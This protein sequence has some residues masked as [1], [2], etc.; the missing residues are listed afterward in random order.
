MIRSPLS[1]TA[2]EC[3]PRRARL[4]AAVLVWTA[5]AGSLLLLVSWPLLGGMI[6][7]NDDM[8]YSRCV[9]LRSP[10]ENL[11]VFWQHRFFRPLDVL[12]GYL[13]DPDTLDAGR[14]VLLHLPALAA[15][16][17][18]LW[19]ALRRLTPNHVMIAWPVAVAWLAAH[20]STAAALWQHDTISQ[21]W[22]AACGLWLGI[23]VWDAVAAPG[24]DRAY[25]RHAAWAAVLTL[26]GLLAK[27]VFCGWVAAASLLLIL[28]ALGALR[29]GDRRAVLRLGGL[30]LATA[31]VAAAFLL[32]RWAF[33]GLGNLSEGPDS[34]YEMQVGSNVVRN[35][36]L[37]AVGYFSAA[38]VHVVRD[39]VAWPLLRVLPLA[40]I[41]TGVLVATT[42]WI[43]S[44]W[45]PRSWP[46][47]PPARTVAAIAL[48]TFLG[49][50]AT[51]PSRQVS[52]VYLMGPNAGAALLVALGVIGLGRMCRGAGWKRKL[53]MAL[54]LGLMATIAGWGM[55]SRAMHARITWVS[56]S[57]LNR[58][59]LD[60]QASLSPRQD[61]T[62]RVFLFDERGET[63]QHCQY[64]I[65]PVQA[66]SPEVT[67]AWLS[68]RDPRR[69]V[70]LVAERPDGV[71]PHPDLVLNCADLPRRPH[72]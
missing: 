48:F 39:P 9:H 13:V 1:E 22:C 19:L 26:A 68:H 15:V 71:P 55:V 51:L 14:T 32:V 47:R 41:A 6:S 57:T 62:P 63:F 11:A 72:W 31:G 33:G 38:P 29:R 4:A 50:A 3:E 59:L 60:Y 70:I 54:A 27:E 25:W 64:V 69:P 65:S 7:V 16:C 2:I 34:R 49:S 61:R 20:T 17:A 52:E 21:T 66:I 67:Q 23:V 28:A 18:A 35:L 40:G 24:Q 12:G 8:T 43:I 37:A 46:N 58:S 10:A 45:N 56:V 30:L 44:W 42:P 36:V 53:A 5:A